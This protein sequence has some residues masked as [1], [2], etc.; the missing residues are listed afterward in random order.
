MGTLGCQPSFGRPSLQIDLWNSKD[1][2][3]VYKTTSAFHKSRNLKIILRTLP[4][5]ERHANMFFMWYRNHTCPLMQ[6]EE[7]KKRR[8]RKRKKKG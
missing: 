8:K 3:L 1:I 6:N 2:Y 4:T 5:P 7:R